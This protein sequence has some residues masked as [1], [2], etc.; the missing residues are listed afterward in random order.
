MKSL[1]FTLIFE[2]SIEKQCFPSILFRSFCCLIHGDRII[3]SSRLFSS[4][5]FSSH[6]SSI[7][8]SFLFCD[9]LG[10]SSNSIGMRD[11]NH[12]RTLSGGWNNDRPIVPPPLPPGCSSQIRRRHSPPSMIDPP[13]LGKDVNS[14]PS[15]SEEIKEE[16]SDES[17]NVGKVIAQLNHRMANANVTSVPTR[18]QTT[19]RRFSSSFRNTIPQSPGETT[20]F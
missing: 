13:M 18:S 2:R 3:N 14:S 16:I 12:R 1:S 10:P 4:L 9:I 15:P 7:D 6:C 20:D 17:V 8:K 11:G 19:N 5:L